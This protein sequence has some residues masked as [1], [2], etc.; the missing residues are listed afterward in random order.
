MLI[1][2]DTY[3]RVDYWLLVPAAGSVLFLVLYIVAAQFY[4]GGSQADKAAP[5]FDWVHNYWCNLMNER[6]GN[7]QLSASRPIALSAMGVLCVTMGLFACRDD[8]GTAAI[9][10]VFSF[11]VRDIEFGDGR[12]E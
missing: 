4:P 1:K 10:M 6:A 12:C 7:G 8:G 11:L 9:E 3:R 2:S 5:G